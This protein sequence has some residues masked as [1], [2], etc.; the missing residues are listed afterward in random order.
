MFSEITSLQHNSPYII[1]TLSKQSTL[2]QCAD[3]SIVVCNMEMSWHGIYW[4]FV[5]GIHQSLVD[6][7][8]KGTSNE[9]LLCFL[10]ISLKMLLN[11]Q[12]IC[13]KF[14]MSSHSCDTT[15]MSPLI[16]H[17]LSKQPTLQQHADCSIVARN[18][19]MSWHGIYWPFVRGIHQSLVDSLHKGPVIQSFYAVEQTIKWPGIWDIMALMW[20]HSYVF[21]HYT[22][23]IK[24]IGIEAA[25]W[26]LCGWL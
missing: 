3:Y 16:I 9:D 25:S 1:H 12:S 6:S 26:L 20:H 4:L 5:R 22:Y 15:V 24:T 13:Q 14:K 19:V 11:K 7:F 2:Q 10:I 8:H 21:I 18:M 17:L 23:V